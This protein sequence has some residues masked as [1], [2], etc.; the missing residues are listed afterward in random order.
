MTLTPFPKIS[1]NSLGV[2]LSAR[3]KNADQVKKPR[4]FPAALV[5]LIYYPTMCTEGIPSNACTF[6]IFIFI[7]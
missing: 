7:E 6:G 1:D 5:F 2:H 3:V 4:M